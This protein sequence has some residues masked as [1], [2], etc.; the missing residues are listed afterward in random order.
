MAGINHPA[1]RG[2]GCSID[3]D[4]GCFIWMTSTGRAATTEGEQA[5]PAELEKQEVIQ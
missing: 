3:H 1:Q 5:A 4:S 2:A